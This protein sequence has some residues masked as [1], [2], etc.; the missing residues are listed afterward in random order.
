MKLRQ[1]ELVLAVAKFGSFS[2]AASELYISQPNIS[3]SISALEEELGYD[4]F[5]RSSQGVA[6][7]NE[8]DLFLRHSK[9]IM[10]EIAGMRNIASGKLHRKFTINTS[11]NHTLINQAFSKLCVAFE[12]GDSANF[13]LQSSNSTQIVEDLYLGKIDLGVFIINK[14]TLDTYQNTLSKKGLELEVFGRLNLN[15]TIGKHHPLLE[16]E[17]FEFNKL[18]QYPHVSYSF[19]T[20][21]DFPDIY[22]MGLVNPEK[23]LVVNDINVRHQIITS[24]N[25]FGIG[26]DIH[27]KTRIIDKIVSIPIPD[28][29]AFLVISYQAKHEKREELAIFK[30]LLKEEYLKLSQ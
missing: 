2:R 5:I 28:T 27:P 29:E 13:T 14:I 17:N 8:G 3:S 15:L 19:N 22:A 1:I 16:E 18:S 9:S 4:I 10:K 7:T 30:K 12:E 20:I 26:C 6:L 24:T 25:A 21:S 11:L 23:M